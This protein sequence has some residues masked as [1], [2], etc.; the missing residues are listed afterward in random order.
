MSERRKILKGLWLLL[1][2]LLAV[3]S[4][5]FILPADRRFNIWFAHDNCM[6][7]GLRQYDRVVL[8][9]TPIDVAFI[10]SSHTLSAINTDI[11]NT[12]GVV[13]VENL[14][15]CRFG[16]N[17]HYVLVK[18]LLQH[19]QPRVVVVEVSERENPG[20]HEEF[21]YYASSA[22]VLVPV[23]FSP[24]GYVK[25]LWKAT[26]VRWEYIRHC[27][28]GIRPVPA[29]TQGKTLPEHTPALAD[30]IALEE[31]KKRNQR[32]TV[33]AGGISGWWKNRFPMAYLDETCK[34]LKIKGCEIV[35]L[36]LPS[37]G[38]QTIPTQA[39]H[40]KRNGRLLIPPAEILNNRAYWGDAD[41]LNSIGSDTLSAWLNT[42]L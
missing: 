23:A 42:Q 17:L 6:E 41:H 13:E 20:G 29:Y 9:T 28:L 14:G 36:Y 7:V 5:L 40:Y 37:Y 12:N 2:P 24:D 39:D 32:D 10:G 16:R 27:L 21:G 33:L 22:D 35:F 3:V 18:E 4:M 25:D 30:S 26:V 15:Y 19:K 34:L 11:L 1:L 8:D 38:A 31:Q